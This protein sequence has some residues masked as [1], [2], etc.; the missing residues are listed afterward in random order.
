V[1]LVD[2][3][4]AQD[5]IDAASGDT[6]LMPAIGVNDVI[7][8]YIRENRPFADAINF[9]CEESEFPPEAFGVVMAT[10]QMIDAAIQHAAARRGREG[11]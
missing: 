7:R 9:I 2:L 3:I 1:R 8:A 10:F 11:S 5:L 4:T 6:A